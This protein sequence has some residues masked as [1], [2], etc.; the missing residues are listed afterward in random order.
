MSFL[1][2]SQ[3]RA[4]LNVA[5]VVHQSACARAPLQPAIASE[6]NVVLRMGWRCLTCHSSVRCDLL[7]YGA[8]VNLCHGTAAMAPP[9]RWHRKCE[10]C[11]KVGASI[12][13][14]R[15]KKPTS[16]FAEQ[17]RLFMNIVSHAVNRTKFQRSQA[18]GIGCNSNASQPWNSQSLR[19]R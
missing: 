9:P 6:L 19:T 5:W 18:P 12:I 1:A 13:C 3:F 17:R 7:R 15:T 14:G 8:P 10:R 2:L 4:T 11:G 16:E